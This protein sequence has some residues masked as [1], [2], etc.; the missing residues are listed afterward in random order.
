MVGRFRFCGKSQTMLGCEYSGI[1]SRSC[2]NNSDSHTTS[3]QGSRFE[4]DIAVR[5]LRVGAFD[6][7]NIINIP[8]AKLIRKLGSLTPEQ[9]AEVEEVILFWLRFKDA[10]IEEDKE[11]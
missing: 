10:D 11:D 7:Q 3:S 2:L 4:V 6:V 5:F 8:H 9:L 1:R